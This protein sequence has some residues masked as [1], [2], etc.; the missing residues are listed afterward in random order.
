[1]NP[2][3]ADIL[4]AV[5]G[6]APQTPDTT[7]NT[8]LEGAGM[9]SSTSSGSGAPGATNPGTPN[10]MNTMQN[11]FNPQSYN[12]LAQMHSPMIR[13]GIGKD[14]WSS[15]MGLDQ[16]AILNSLGLGGQ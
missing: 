6:T 2:K 9:P 13:H 12:P 8:G 15:N 1:M 4:A 10:Y 5:Q 3:N 16:Q 7:L 14:N 11:F